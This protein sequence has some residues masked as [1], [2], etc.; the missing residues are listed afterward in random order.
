MDI[1]G[2]FFDSQSSRRREARLRGHDGGAGRLAVYDT[3]GVLLAEADTSGLRIS[4]RVGNTPRF[5]RFSDGG[6]FET[7]DNDA[8]DRLAKTL[9]PRAGLAHWLESRLRYAVIGLV[10]T[11]LF[12][13]ASIQYGIPF[14]AHVAAFAISA[15]N[16][17]RIGQGVL[18]M[19]DK[20]FFSPSQL[21]PA[22]QER[23]R[24]RFLDFIGAVDGIP[25]H[26]E[27]RHGDKNIG[28]NALAL[29][30]GTIVFTDQLVK[31][32]KNDEELLGV[33][34]HEAGHVERRHAMR[35]ILQQSA[36]A[37]VIVAVTGD[38]STV[39]SIVTAA[40]AFLV[41]TGYS[42]D[43]E[44]EADDFAVARLQEGGISPSH[45]ADMLAR[46]EASRPDKDGK[47]GK[48]DKDDKDGKNVKNQDH[49]PLNDY[50]STHPATAERLRRINGG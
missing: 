25:L 35:G 28:A 42:R 46:L 15:E 13:W 3:A 43:F 18:D 6:V 11:I 7:G 5:L 4:S 36:L 19:L 14:C 29:P 48:G 2:N 9:S 31:L 44:R 50:I 1:R 23:L 21:P 37:A 33:F 8:V 17:R 12:T 30:S 34:S 16:N 20:A 47:D 26:V 32:A 27:F 41:Q 22:E 39:A 38:V 40:P 45:F 10:V 24:R 49:S